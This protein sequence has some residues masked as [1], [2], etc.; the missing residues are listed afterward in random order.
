[1]E[2]LYLIEKSKLET[3]VRNALLYEALDC[4]GVDNWE[5]CGDSISDFCENNEVDDI[6]ELVEDVMNEFNK[7]NIT[8]C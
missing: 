6:E 4:G 7:H 8:E 2:E 1:M 5:W 3:L